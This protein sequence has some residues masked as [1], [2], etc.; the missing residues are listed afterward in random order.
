M[1]QSSADDDADENRLRDRLADSA[2]DARE[3]L[4]EATSKWFTRAKDALGPAARAAGERTRTEIEDVDWRAHARTAAPYA[5]KAAGG[6]LVLVGIWWVLQAM[7]TAF[8]PISTIAYVVLFVV[9]AVG[10]PLFVILF[11]PSFPNLMKD[12]YGKMHWF[13]GAL[14]YG[15]TILVETDDGWTICPARDGKVYINGEWEDIEG[16]FKY[17]STILGLPFGIARDKS[18]D[19]AYADVRVDPRA[20]ALSDGGVVASPDSGSRNR[21]GYSEANPDVDVSG[22]DGIWLV[23]LVRVM[24]SGL[25]HAGDG[26]LVE[27][28]EMDKLQDEAKASRMQGWKPVVGMIAGLILG[29]G[30]GFIIVLY[31]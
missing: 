26:E 30:T 8:G 23:D 12:I 5:A 9:G 14:T 17:Q 18:S 29:A 11:A 19:D 25:V 2:S 10:T 6:I 27:Q 31:M 21:G 20:E 13:L 24:A 1:T 16:G 22:N 7:W 15:N 3:T 4:G 28:A